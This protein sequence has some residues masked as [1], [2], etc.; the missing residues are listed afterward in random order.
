MKDLADTPVPLDTAFRAARSLLDG[1]PEDWVAERFRLSLDEV[2]WS[3]RYAE[4]AIKEHYRNKDVPIADFDAFCARHILDVIRL[5]LT[6]AEQLSLP[7][8]PV[9]EPDAED[10]EASKKNGASQGEA[11]EI[12]GS[13]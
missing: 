6:W 8:V 5:L 4:S 9:S 10:D 13:P 7:Q 12:P 11:G 1:A 2:D 3:R